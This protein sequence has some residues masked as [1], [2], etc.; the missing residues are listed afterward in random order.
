MGKWMLVP[1]IAFVLILA[2]SW[3][4]LIL[5]SRFSYKA[6]K[7]NAGQGKAYACGE[8]NYDPMSQPDYSTFFPYAFFFALAHVAT[9]IMT[10]VPTESLRIFVLAAIYVAG[11]A[12]GLYILFRK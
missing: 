6:G 8:D 11:A 2:A 12:L 10:T 3:L 4:I 7:H 9:L 5:L 1:P